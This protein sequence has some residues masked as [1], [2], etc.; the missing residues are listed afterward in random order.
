WNQLR[1]RFKIDEVYLT[2]ND[3]EIFSGP[4][5]EQQF[6]VLEDL[7][8]KGRANG[9]Y[10]SLSVDLSLNRPYGQ[11]SLHGGSQLKRPFRY[12]AS[13]SGRNVNPDD[14]I[15]ADIDTT[16]LTFDVIANGLATDLK[17][18]VMELDASVYNSSF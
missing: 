9:S 4:L 17:D 8:F 10:D 16:N 3:V 11:L 14:L 15:A 12:T 1:Y 7:Q 18:A 2:K 13:L 5:N 6:D